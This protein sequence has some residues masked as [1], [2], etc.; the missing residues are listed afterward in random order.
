MS[1]EMSVMVL[2]AGATGGYLAAR[3][4]KAGVP[5]TLIA[6]G[7]NLRQIRE[8]G[9][10]LE[11]ARA[12]REVVR[13]DRV[14][15]VEEVDRPADLVLFCV[16]SYDTE[17]AARSVP[18]LVASDGHVLCL[19]NG[20]KNEQILA[21][22]LGP[23]RILSGVLYIGADRLGPGVIRC[24]A[25]PKLIVGP[26]FGLDLGASSQVRELFSRAGIE[27]AV[28]PEV[29]SSKW[30]KFLFNCGLNPLT[31]ITGKRLGELLSYPATAEVFDLLVAEAAAAA[32]AAG[33]PLAPD[34]RVRVQHTAARMD[35]SSSMAEDLAAGRKIELEAFTGYVIEL[36]AAH[37][38]PTPVTRAAH[39]MLVAL[40]S[41]TAS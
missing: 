25:P 12:A 19:Q 18:P 5:V 33:A 17:T 29:S 8:H 21:G 28:E 26:Y 23:S 13:P 40:D 38:V 30:Q 39:G 1:T 41:A 9:I 11:D 24:S 22:K 7:A 4:A 3:L 2:G 31:A 14:L 35:I 10:V 6:R 37:G 36:G 16:K 34:H 15:A 20:V 32:R 27:A